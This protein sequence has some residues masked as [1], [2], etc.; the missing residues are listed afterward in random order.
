MPFRPSLLARLVAE[1]GA[2]CVLPHG[3]DPFFAPDLEEYTSDCA[4][5]SPLLAF[6]TT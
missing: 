3:L 5:V 1:G 2:G 6:K 4:M